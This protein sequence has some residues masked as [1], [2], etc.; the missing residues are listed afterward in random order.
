L[1]I[2]G[3]LNFFHDFA[4]LGFGPVIKPVLL[5]A[6]QKNINNFLFSVLKQSFSS[7]HLRRPGDVIYSLKLYF[8]KEEFFFLFW[9]QSFYLTEK[10][11]SMK[12][13]TTTLMQ[14]LLIFEL[15][16]LVVYLVSLLGF[17]EG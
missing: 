3:S 14:C 9:K 11:P 17:P 4:L 2:S 8:F 15:V 12:K 5:R 10:V 16:Q 13:R 6:S 1:L 7:K